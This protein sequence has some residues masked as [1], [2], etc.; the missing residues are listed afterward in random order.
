MKKITTRLTVLALALLLGAC[1]VTQPLA[2]PNTISFAD[3]PYG[4]IAIIKAKVV[5]TPCPSGTV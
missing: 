1:S 2:P 4:S 5:I 3:L